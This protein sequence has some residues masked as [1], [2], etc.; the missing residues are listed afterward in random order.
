MYNTHAL[1][2]IDVYVCQL[3]KH[4][5]EKWTRGLDIGTRL[6]FKFFSGA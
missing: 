1:R 3:N 2:E 6:T 4:I 5:D